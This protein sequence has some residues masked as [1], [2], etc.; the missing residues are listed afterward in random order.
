[1]DHVILARRR[2]HD[3]TDDEIL[4]AYRNPVRILDADDLTLLIGP[5]TPADSSSSVSPP[6]KASSSSC[7]A[8]P[9]RPKFLI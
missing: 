2:K 3:I 7:T 9:A 1:V 5:D 4:H 8:M 6:L